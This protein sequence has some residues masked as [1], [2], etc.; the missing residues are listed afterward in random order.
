MM[1]L[2]LAIGLFLHVGSILNRHAYDCSVQM[3]AFGGA[4]LARYCNGGSGKEIAVL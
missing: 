2:G 3:I 1:L 4:C